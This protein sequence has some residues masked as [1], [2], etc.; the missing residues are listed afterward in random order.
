[1]KAENVRT[2]AQYVVISRMARQTPPPPSLLQAMNGR[3]LTRSQLCAVCQ[4]WEEHGPVLQPR[5]AQLHFHNSSVRYS[6]GPMYWI[7]TQHVSILVSAECDLHIQLTVMVLSHHSCM[8]AMGA[9][10]SQHIQ[11]DTD[12]DRP[13]RAAVGCPNC[14]ECAGPCSKSSASHCCLQYRCLDKK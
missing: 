3:H 11:V 12:T 7:V 2:A 14:P 9:A 1:M 13:D 4:R 10:H 6:T 5:N 8:L